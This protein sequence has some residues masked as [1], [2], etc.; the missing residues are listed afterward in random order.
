MPRRSSRL[1]HLLLAKS[2]L[3]AILIT[4]VAVAFYFATT[5]PGIRGWLDSADDKTVAGW[6]VDESNLPNQ[7]EVQL[8]IDGKFVADKAAADFRPDVHAANRAQDDW[9]GF[10]FNTPPLQAGAH[11]ARAYAVHVA[12]SGMRRTLQLIGKPV[13]FQIGVKR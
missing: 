3:E 5:N 13:R 10:V 12:P 11:E 4:A 8:F 9:H 2:I 7:V 6:V 1:I